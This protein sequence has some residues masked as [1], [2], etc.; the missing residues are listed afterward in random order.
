MA[1]PSETTHFRHHHFRIISGVYPSA[2]FALNDDEPIGL[3]MVSWGVRKFRTKQFL[4]S[5]AIYWLA[6][7]MYEILTPKPPTCWVF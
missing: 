4:G 6:M 2:F 7:E 1:F 5:Q 3:G